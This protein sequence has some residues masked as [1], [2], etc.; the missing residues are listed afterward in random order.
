MYVQKRW[1]VHL[2]II[3]CTHSTAYCNQRLTDDT[4]MILYTF[5]KSSTTLATLALAIVFGP[6]TACSGS[7]SDETEAKALRD[8]IVS[9][10]QRGKNMRNQSRFGEALRLHSEGLKLAKAIGDTAEWIQALNNIGTD[11]RRMGI[12]DV[13]Q[14]YHYNAYRLCEESSDTAY[15]MRKNRV[16]SLNGLGNIY[17]SIRNYE[18]ADS[19]FR[20]A[21]AGEHA[22]GSNT[23]QAINYAN[24][25][26]I[27]NARGDDDK[28]MQY[29]RKSMDLNRADNN[30]LGIALCHTYF[31]N[32]YEKRHQY[33]NALR[34]YSEAYRIMEASEDKWHSLE[35]LL[36]LASI[37]IDRDNDSRAATLLARAMATADSI[38]SIEHLASIHNLYYRMYSREGQYR[39]ALKHHVLSTTLQDSVVDMEKSNRIHNI[40]ITIE[41]GRQQ[42]RVD[43][44]QKELRDE[45]SAKYIGYGILIVIVILLM[46]AVGLMYYSARVR[47]HSHRV[48]R[49]ASRMRESF[50]TNITHEFRTPLTV[51]LGLS[52]GIADDS[53][54]NPEIRHKAQTIQRNGDRLLTLI[55]QLLDISRIKSEIGDP[56]WRHGNIVAQVS[57]LV[58]C[59]REYAAGRNIAIK[60]DTPAQGI[61][62]DFVPDYVNK[63]FSNLMSNALKF[64]PNGGT[65]TI[66]M[67]KAD[68]MLDITFAD[69]GS[70]IPEDKI[71]HIFK[72]FYSDDSTSG[73]GIGLALVRQIIDAVDGTIE[74]SSKHGHGTTFHITVPIHN[75]AKPFSE[76]DASVPSSIPTAIPDIPSSIEDE[77]AD[78]KRKHV[79]VIEDNNDVA[80]YICSQLTDT[81]TIH[82]A[83]NGQQGLTLAREIIPDII[84]TDV[85]MPG[86]DGLE[87]CRQIRKDSLV[88]HI[89][90]I[91]VTARITEADKIRGLEAGADAYLAKPF[92]ANE[93][94][95]RVD[96]LLEQRA[97]LR[98]KFATQVLRI[99]TP[100]HSKTMTENTTS[101]QFLK[102][103][104]ESIR[105]M[106]TKGNDVSVTSLASHMGLNTRQMHRKITS[107]LGQT[108]VSFIRYAKI[109]YACELLD[110]SPGTPLKNVAIDCGFADYSHF[111]RVFKEITETTPTDY[112]GKKA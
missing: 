18:R 68:T 49:E 101:D 11:Y 20:L 72:P 22:L 6:L 80:E 36:A 93:L 43:L 14:E 112:V 91:M 59:S 34:E 106:L 75:T 70:G 62:M 86:I 66:R 40:G 84:I 9:L 47:A 8:T 54:C 25:G 56:D 42:Q 110:K 5:F 37:Y 12:Y 48:L 31:G 13:A 17:L 53:E 87:V 107:I 23:G 109:Q 63:L 79:L 50:F 64:T 7:G 3:D 90:I 57:M 74:V 4:D 24:L 97:M 99:T 35:P 46:L 105:N 39:E 41:R 103:A 45:R 38:K 2:A 16:V 15:A 71:P 44:A 102:Q 26:A 21:L 33:D 60:M 61:E 73:T 98:D 77:P 82:R 78:D 94:C 19:A 52:K 89:P 58:E 76:D 96:K 100:G 69:T 30:D 104:T 111:A 92:N 55:T 28:A 67:K 29:Y 81:Y 88:N 95:T 1:Q 85:M 32:I 83:E 65:I 108:P 27:Y 10:R 51:I